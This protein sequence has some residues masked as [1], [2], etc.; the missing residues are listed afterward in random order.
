MLISARVKKGE[1]AIGYLQE[2]RNR[3]QQNMQGLAEELEKQKLMVIAFQEM[4]E[5]ALEEVSNINQSKYELNR[6]NALLLSQNEDL[7][8]ANAVLAVSKKTTQTDNIALREENALLSGDLETLGTQIEELQIRCEEMSGKYERYRVEVQVLRSENKLLKMKSRKLREEVGVQR[9][10]E[11]DL[12]NRLEDEKQRILAMEVDVEAA[13]AE[14]VR[15]KEIAME[16]TA[17]LEK[18]RKKSR[19]LKDLN[20]QLIE[21]KKKQ[22]SMHAMFDTF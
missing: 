1:L 5:H 21:K 9:T 16:A 6:E 2:E 10:V 7:R 22:P 3:L 8:E 15:Q 20:E 12:R 17:A 11:E 19:G 18:S 14:A 13:R 4:Y